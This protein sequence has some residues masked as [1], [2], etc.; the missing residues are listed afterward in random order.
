[1]KFFIKGNPE[2]VITLKPLINASKQLS[3]P[4][5]ELDLD[6]LELFRILTTEF[7]ISNNK[8]AEILKSKDELYIEE[9]LDAVRVNINK[10]TV[11]NIPAFTVKAIEEDYRRKT[12]KAEIEKE[13]RKNNLEAEK[14]AE[15]LTARQQAAREQEM[16]DK[17]MLRYEKLEGD[18]KAVFLAEFRQYLVA[19]GNSIVVSRYDKEGIAPGA[20]EAMFW[21]F[22]RES[23]V[24]WKN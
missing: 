23:F 4:V 7:G 10:G 19:T 12:P 1:M 20:V 2:N 13:A 17:A 14:E 18:E 22:V 11:Q 16:L 24:S 15:Q 8:A 9:V 5:P 6:N 21:V 3:L